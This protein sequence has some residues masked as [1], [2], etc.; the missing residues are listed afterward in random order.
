MLDETKYPNDAW[1]VDET[2]T[3]AFFSAEFFLIYDPA[4]LNTHKHR[5]PKLPNSVRTCKCH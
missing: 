2:D 3:N 1:K 4:N 5:L